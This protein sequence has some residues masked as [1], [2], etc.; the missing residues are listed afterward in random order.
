MLKSQS[1]QCRSLTNILTVFLLLVWVAVVYRSSVNS[2][3][4]H[5]HAWTQSDRYALT[6]GYL[7]NGFGLF[8]PSTPNLWPK[9]PPEQMPAQLQGITKAD[10]PL[11]EY[12]AAQLMKVSGMRQPFFHRGLN[13]ALMLTGLMMLFAL[14]RNMGATLTMAWLGVAFA[15]LSPVAAYYLDGFIPGIPA[16]AMVMAAY[17]FL[18]RYAQS[19][20]LKSYFIAIGLVTLAALI[21]PPMLMALPGMVLAALW[22]DGKTRPGKILLPPLLSLLAMAGLY[23]HNQHLAHTYGSLFISQLMPA[24]SPAMLLTLAKQ[25]LAQWKLEYFSYVQYLLLVFALLMLLI[26]RHRLQ[27][28]Q[29]GIILLAALSHLLAALAYFVAM[30]KQFPDHDYYFLESFYLP[31]LMLLS[32]G[33][34]LPQADKPLRKLSFGV[35]YVLAFWLMADA[36][37]ASREKRYTSHPWDQTETTRK[38]FEGSAAWLDQLGIPR[39]A[40][41]LVPD[42]YTT[43]VP[44]LLMERK[45]FTVIN[46]TREN[47][48]A[49]LRLPFD[50]VVVANRSLPADLLRNL[51][52]LTSQ[53][54]PV[55]NNGR[56]GLYRYDS[57]SGEK[58]LRDLVMP[59][60]STL[61]PVNDSR[62]V[63]TPETEFA[64]LVSAPYPAAALSRALLFE[65]AATADMIPVK[66]LHLVVDISQGE[67][68][69]FYDS[70]RLDPFFE[71]T[72]GEAIVRT[73]VNLPGLAE[74]GTRLKCYLWNAG[75]N[76][77]I[78]NN[79]TVEILSY[80]NLK[81]HSQ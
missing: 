31:L 58:Q 6:I 39:N 57:L 37:L 66:N 18:H 27:T 59:D 19:P 12:L 33:L 28:V 73:F 61:W 42:S 76:R 75:A 63:L 3:P 81:N 8:R 1:F 5:V 71:N 78:I 16:L 35:V 15:M 25:S 34:S 69:L 77:L 51:P 32:V 45:G 29:A 49:S 79:P 40:R 53:L 38:L 23:V 48:E 44:L 74:A 10:L 56:L 26:F 54:I 13:L 22:I 2:F 36:A 17:Y 68:Q 46:T 64:E 50:Y 21:R 41:M 7:E 20:D 9:Y 30:A 72:D 80:D 67:K 14:M 11:T 55:A 70:F 4:S 65:A 47:L 43:N 24:E 60:Q 52:G 62:I